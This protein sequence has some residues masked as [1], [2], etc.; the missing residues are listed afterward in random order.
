MAHAEVRADMGGLVE[1]R[2]WLFVAV[3]EP[4]GS[5]RS[6]EGGSK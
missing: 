1:F 6:G 4:R 3:V 5:D 2:C